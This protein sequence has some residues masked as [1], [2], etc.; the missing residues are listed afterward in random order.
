MFKDKDKE[1]NQ[2]IKFGALLD[3]GNVL[4]FCCGNILDGDDCDIIDYLYDGWGDLHQTL[5]RHF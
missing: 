3:D 4:C 2:D 1:F 5:E